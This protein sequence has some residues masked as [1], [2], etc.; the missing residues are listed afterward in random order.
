MLKSTPL[1]SV[2]LPTYNRAKTLARAIDSVLAQTC[3]DFELIVVVDASPD[4]TAAVLGRYSGLPNV[5]IIA[6][7]RGNCSAARNIG[8]AAS[9][10]RYV[11]FQD[12]DDEWL[13]TMLE[14]AVK[15]LADTGPEVGVFYSDMTRVLAS[16]KS[17]PFISPEISRG[18]FINEDT[19]D[20]QVY[21]LGI[22][23][24]VI[25][26]DC[27]QRA[28]LFDE[29]IPRFVDLE[30][31]IR[32]TDHFE[33]IHHREAL[34]RYCET[35]GISTNTKA[36]V[37]ARQHLIA[38][39][40]HR[41]SKNKHHL[42]MQHVLLGSACNDNGQKLMSAKQ[43]LKALLISPCHPLVLRRAIKILRKRLTFR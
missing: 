38:K 9:R 14:N 37:A 39:Y 36:L 28:G 21:G 40:H 22:Q 25:K 19:L 32:L 35:E 15:R 23:A 7:T 3:K 29:A 33:F 6:S 26:R 16:G 11:A 27:F 17:I 34:V 30:L 42:A 5:R 31:F 41:L 8:V 1:I 24:T 4:E 2:V 20:F 18:G 43:A 12:S 10:S 13:P